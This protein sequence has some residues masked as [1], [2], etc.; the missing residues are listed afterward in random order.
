MANTV[1]RIKRG[2]NRIA[3]FDSIIQS[4][5]AASPSSLSALTPIGSPGSGFGSNNSAVTTPNVHRTP[6]ATAANATTTRRPEWAPIPQRDP[7]A[8]VTQLA[9]GS[10]RH[11]VTAAEYSRRLHHHIRNAVQPDELRRYN[12]HLRLLGGQ[13]NLE[14]IVPVA[15]WSSDPTSEE[16]LAIAQRY[17][18]ASAND[19][20]IAEY[21][22]EY[23]PEVRAEL[24]ERRALEARR[25]QER[26]ATR[27]AR[28]LPTAV[29][30]A[31]AAAEAAAMDLSSTTAATTTTSRAP[32]RRYRN[33]MQDEME[34]AYTHY[35]SLK[36]RRSKEFKLLPAGVVALTDFRD[37]NISRGEQIFEFGYMLYDMF[38]P[39]VERTPEQAKFH[40]HIMRLCA[41]HYYG[42]D[43]H[44]ARISLLKRFGIRQFAVA[45]FFAGPRRWGKSVGLGMDEAVT[46]Y[47][48]RGMK[49]LSFAQTLGIATEL[50]NKG[51]MYFSM[52]PKTENRQLRST[53]VE[54]LVT[55]FEEVVADRRQL[56]MQ[57]RRYNRLT[58]RSC[59]VNSQYSTRSRARTPAR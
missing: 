21:E 5:I 17:G 25:E 30:T 46:M 43:F 33:I 58:A 13:I 45:V 36:T 38:G 24:A 18:T 29:S 15:D 51:K 6:T 23:P 32:A 12:P 26:D 59:I 1:N 28:S 37:L 20:D 35:V 42:N 55:W 22:H 10:N 7:D 54:L 34:S 19:A 53:T 4:A 39:N 44:K 31:A 49:C 40:D 41:P 9:S 57:S 50:V 27:T 16:R 2:A 3:L 47:I 8:I 11:D 52:L 14:D 56:L 48:G